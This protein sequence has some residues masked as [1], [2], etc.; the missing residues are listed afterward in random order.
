MQHVVAARGKQRHHRVAD[1]FVDEASLLEHRRLHERQEG[2]DE[3]ET[4]PGCKPFRQR[5]EAADVGE[6]DGHFLFDLIATGDVEDASLPSSS[7]SCGGTKR[8]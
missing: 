2:I 1:V 3:I 5:G 8:A 7:I 6:Q 4:L